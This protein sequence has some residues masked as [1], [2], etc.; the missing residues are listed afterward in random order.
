[1]PTIVTN[2][3]NCNYTPLCYAFSRMDIVEATRKKCPCWEC[4]VKVT[5][6]RDTDKLSCPY[7][8]EFIDKLQVVRIHYQH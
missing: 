5:C 8:M 3:I 4:L 6:Q 1:M 2:C 7:R